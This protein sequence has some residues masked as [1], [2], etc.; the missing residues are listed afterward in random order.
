VCTRPVE[1]ARYQE[2]TRQGLRVEPPAG[3]VGG[4]CGRLISSLFASCSNANPRTRT[5]QDHTH[6]ILLSAV[7]LGLIP[8]LFLFHNIPVHLVHLAT[9]LTYSRTNVC[10]NC[11]THTRKPG[12]AHAHAH[13]ES[14][15]HATT[16]RLHALLPRTPTLYSRLPSS[17]QR[18]QNNVGA[19][20]AMHV[21]AIH[22]WCRP[23]ITL[24]YVYAA[25]TEHARVRDRTR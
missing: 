3:F 18:H 24:A 4:R 20:G 22:V 21:G 15:A 1:L 25:A 17:T 12:H 10:A 19:V 5:I 13:R 7:A 14:E 8:R 23:Q 9:R 6:T 11:I 2:C 16:Q